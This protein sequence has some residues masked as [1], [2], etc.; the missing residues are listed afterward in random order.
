LDFKRNLKQ[1]SIYQHGRQR[2]WTS[3]NTR[4]QEPRRSQRPAKALA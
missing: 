4:Q 2:R 1:L 3:L